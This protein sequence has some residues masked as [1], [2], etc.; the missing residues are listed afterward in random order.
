MYREVSS[1]CFSFGAVLGFTA[2]FNFGLLHGWVRPLGRVLGC[3]VESQCP[4]PVHEQSLLGKLCGLKASK[5]K[6]ATTVEASSNKYIRRW[7]TQA[8]SAEVCPEYPYLKTSR[9]RAGEGRKQLETVTK[10]GRYHPQIRRLRPPGLLFAVSG[11]KQAPKGHEPIRE[12][13]HIHISHTTQR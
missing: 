11:L 1:R 10:A 7:R 2:L 12:P 9:C 6:A 4:G 13:R 8:G 3:V 5:W